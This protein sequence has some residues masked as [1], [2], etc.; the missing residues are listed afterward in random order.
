MTDVGDPIRIR[1]V[2]PSVIPVPSPAPGPGE[3]PEP[4]EPR[5]PAREPDLI[6]A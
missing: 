5:E 2:E 1:E 6:P 4:A 3:W